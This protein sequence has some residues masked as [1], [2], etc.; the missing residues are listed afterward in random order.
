MTGAALLLA[1]WV[2]WR[3]GY[4]PIKS[5]WTTTFNLLAGGICLWVF[6]AFHLLVDFRPE[7]NWS[8]P[9]QVV[10]M[11][12]LTIYLAERILSFGDI[13]AFFF[14]GIAARSGKWEGVVLAAG[15]LAI[16]WLLLWFLWRKKA[17]LRV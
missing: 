1:G 7:S 17:F 15:V 16:E 3:L 12:P 9:L 4:P 10:G 14:G 2:C 6:V 13:S 8:F 5:A 11:N